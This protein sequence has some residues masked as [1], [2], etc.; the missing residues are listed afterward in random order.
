M[1][2]GLM[3]AHRTGKTKLAAEFVK[4][5]PSFKFAATSVSAIM[6]SRQMDP[7]FDYPISVRIAM[8]NII[9]EELDR[10]YGLHKEK[11]VFDRTPLDAAAYLLADVQRENVDPGLHPEICAYVQRAIDITN[12]RFSMLVF[13]PPVLPLVHEAGKAP[14]TP[15]YVEHISQIINGLRTDERMKVK[16]FLM[17]RHYVDL[18]KRVAGMSACV[19]RVFQHHMTDTETMM[20]N[21][22]AMH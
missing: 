2:V 11:T 3:G 7:A 13:I 16:H 22:M 21:G 10:H 5:N 4:K 15:A 9:L 20:L 19:A 18:D 17:P 8:Q 12:R 6:K 14:A 1:I